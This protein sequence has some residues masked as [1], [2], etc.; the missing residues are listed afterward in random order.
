MLFA[1]TDETSNIYQIEKD[2]YN[3]KTHKKIP[4]KLA[5]KLMQ[6]ERK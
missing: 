3:N 2:E 5:T 4:T 1:F 6:M